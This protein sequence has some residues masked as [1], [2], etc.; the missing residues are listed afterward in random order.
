MNPRRYA[1]RCN[2]DIILTGCE[3][4]IDR[5]K[6]SFVELPGPLSWQVGVSVNG[7]NEIVLCEG[8]RTMLL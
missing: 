5:L 2:H 7:S 3:S 8:H 4:K 6:G 1:R